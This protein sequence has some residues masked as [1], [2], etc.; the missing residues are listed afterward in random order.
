MRGRAVGR[1]NFDGYRYE[2]CCIVLLCAQKIGLQLTYLAGRSH[3]AQAASTQ[4]VNLGLGVG[5]FSHLGVG[6]A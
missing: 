2:A 4:P 1:P 3:G 5:V 6:V